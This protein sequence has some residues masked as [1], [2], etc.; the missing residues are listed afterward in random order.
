VAPEYDYCVALF[1]FF[2]ENVINS[3]SVRW[4]CVYCW[5]NTDVKFLIMVY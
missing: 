2:K 5:M 3:A 1:P 4:H